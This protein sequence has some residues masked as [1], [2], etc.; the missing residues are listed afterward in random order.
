MTSLQ[1]DL[2]CEL[3]YANLRHG[4]VRQALR[5]LG[6]LETWAPSHSDLP[7]LKAYALVQSGRGEEALRLMPQLD[8]PSAREVP[9]LRSFAL[10]AAGK[11]DEARQAFA[12][13]I[14][15]KGV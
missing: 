6:L 8:D 10:R 11:A 9:L 4:N 5:L 7:R 3:A 13:F 12:T 1:Q 2:L 15:A 14:S